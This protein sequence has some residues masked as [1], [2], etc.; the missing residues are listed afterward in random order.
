MTRTT[1]TP[2]RTVRTDKVIL[3]RRQ[4]LLRSVHHRPHDAPAPVE[5]AVAIPD[6]RPKLARFLT[7]EFQAKV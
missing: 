2:D 1:T 7:C 5:V 4:D 3:R 6:E